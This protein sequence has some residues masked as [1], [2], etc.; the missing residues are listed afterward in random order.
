MK[1]EAD[2]VPKNRSNASRR[3]FLKI[4]GLT[5]GGAAV[6]TF[7]LASA[8]KPAKDNTAPITDFP[9]TMTPGQSSSSQSYYPP[10]RMSLMPVPGTTVEV[11]SDRL[12]SMDHIWVLPT[13]VKEAKLGI[14]DKIQAL[15]EAVKSVTIPKV[16]TDITRGEAFGFIE[17]YKMNMDLISP[18]SGTVSTI[19]PEMANV[20]ETEYGPLNLDPYG[21]GWMLSLKL[22]NEEEVQELLTP[23]EYITLTA[24]TITAT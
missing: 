1:M 22:L 5:M 14:T 2:M 12:Y 16:G 21:K 15:M 23:E 17:G 24:G 4:L 20:K 18:V 6:S 8:C 10:P 3:Q 13:S 11:A 7:P 9:G 19:N